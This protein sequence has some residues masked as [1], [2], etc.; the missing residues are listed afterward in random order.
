M[1]VEYYN[2]LP[3]IDIIDLD[4]N[5]GDRVEG[6]VNSIKR[7]CTTTGFFYI[8]FDPDFGTNCQEM[9]EAGRQ[10]YSLPRDEILKLE[11]D[12][13]SQMR[14]RGMPIPGTGAGLRAQGRDHAFLKDFRDTFH[15]SVPVLDDDTVNYASKDYS[16]NGKTKWPNPDLLPVGWRSVVSN[17]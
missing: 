14:I 3:I 8:R 11:Q 15:I 4:W 10:L 1:E 9:L 7:A 6:L 5:D 16:G 17:Q 12:P 13:S 2:S